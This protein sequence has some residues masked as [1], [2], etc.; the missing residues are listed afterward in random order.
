[1]LCH[2]AS[3]LVAADKAA[4]PRDGGETLQ[5]EGGQL[6]GDAYQD[7]KLV[8][9]THVF[10]EIDYDDEKA[11]F[12]SVGRNRF[13]QEKLRAVAGWSGVVLG[14]IR[15]HGP[16]RWWTAKDEGGTTTR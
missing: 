12:P 16:F 3:Q 15:E 4:S 1:M 5:D 11:C 9:S 10:R 8:V 13:F 2:A 7:V 14:M 6:P